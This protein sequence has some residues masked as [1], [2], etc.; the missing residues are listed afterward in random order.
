MSTTEMCSTMT[1]RSVAPPHPDNTAPEAVA[2]QVPDY[3][4]FLSSAKAYP[5][6]TE[7]IDVKETHKSWVFLVGPDVYKL[8]KSVKNHLQDLTTSD[9]RATNARNEVRLNRRLAPD[10][11]LGVIALTLSPNGELSIGGQGTAVDW[12]VHMRRVPEAFMLDKMIARGN[13]R[14]EQI[15]ALIDRLAAFYRGLPPARLSPE[16]YVSHFKKEQSENRRVLMKP[17]FPFEQGEMNALL[18]AFEKLHGEIR[19]LLEERVR[20]G[21]I[22]EGHGDLRPEH[23]CLTDPPVMIDCLE[24]NLQLRLVD[25][26][27]E[28]TYLGVECALLGASWIGEQL[29]A[30]YADRVND[31]CPPRL[32]SFYEAY[33]SLVR[34]RLCLAHLLDPGP[35]DELKWVGKAGGYLAVSRRALINPGTPADRSA[36]RRGASGG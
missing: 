4:T 31:H 18:D 35:Q 29:A 13:V 1:D 20:E 19:S 30:G 24:F 15:D 16:A 3:V 5:G 26:H 32:R 12:L 8:K 6:C 14:A 25:P 36:N 33:R 10:V 21:R 11:Y 34:A 22:V 23:V 17:Q 2:S 7:P 9:A 27:D 28:L